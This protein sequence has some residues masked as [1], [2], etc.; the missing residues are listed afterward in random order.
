MNRTDLLKGAFTFLLIALIALW[1]LFVTGCGPVIRNTGTEKGVAP[2]S[3]LTRADAESLAE[4][5]CHL[6]P[7]LTW[8]QIAPTGSM[9]PLLNSHALVITEPTDGSDLRL[10]QW[11]VFDRGDSPR[12]LHRVAM[13]NATHFIASGTSNRHSDGWLPRDRVHSRVV[14]T[15]YTSAPL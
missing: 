7:G 12:V 1:A 13:L 4:L 15:L 5:I 14:A 3:S 9:E 8:S 2:T 11:V 10:G 6:R